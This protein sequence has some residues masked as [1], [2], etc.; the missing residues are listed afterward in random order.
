MTVLVT[1]C[2]SVIVNGCLCIQTLPS[3]LAPYGQPPMNATTAVMPDPD[4]LHAGFTSYG[5]ISR[6]EISIVLCKGS[7]G[8][9]FRMVTLLHFS[10]LGG[11]GS[12][13]CTICCWHSSPS[14]RDKRPSNET[15]QTYLAKGAVGLRSEEDA[16]SLDSCRT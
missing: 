9:R 7:Y 2:C 11:F 15:V 10:L 12:N 14:S 13:V 4:D 8:N 6:P 1:S 5:T 16:D 3:L